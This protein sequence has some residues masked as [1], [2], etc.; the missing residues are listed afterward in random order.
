MAQL[1]TPV[2]PEYITVHLG[3]PSQPAENIRVSFPDYIKN[4]ASSEIYPNWPESAIRANILAQISYALNRIYTE[5][6]RSQGYDFDITSTTQYDQK[7]IPNRDIFENISRIV[8][9]IFNDYVVKRGTVQPYFTQYCNGTTTK[10]EGLSQWGTVDLAREGLVP[11]E[12]LQRYYGDDINIVFNAPVAEV[13]E[14]YPGIALRLGSVGENV[15]VIQRQ[16]NRIAD[17]YPAIPKISETNGLFNLETQNAVKKFQSI[18]NLTSDGIVGKSTWYKIKSIYNGIKRLN[19]LYSE[20]LTPEEVNRL[21][22]ELLREGDTGQLVRQVQYLLAVI[23]Y[24]DDQIPIP[25]VNGI[26]DQRTKETVMAFQRQYGLTPD[27]ILGPATSAKLLEIYRATV[28]NVPQNI[29]PDSSLIYPGRYLIRGISGDDVTDLQRLLNRAAETHSFIPKVDVDGNYGAATE[30]AVRAVQ[31]R[32]NLEVNGI[33][34]PITWDR[35][36]RLAE[37]AA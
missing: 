35:I 36:V 4:V 17:N 37:G 11:Y 15:R 32:E 1:S 12:I 31:Q 26:F 28:A 20:G 27:G 2:I 19:E 6:Y 8:D 29:V 33:V 13:R 5:Y 10:C 14:S 7:F 25:P 18:F 23:A 30:A 24:F 9:D 22:P 16:L 21:Y 34:G 3:L